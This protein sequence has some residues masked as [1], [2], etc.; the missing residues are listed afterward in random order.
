M[1]ESG[2]SRVPG[3]AIQIVPLRIG[4]SDYR[5]RALSDRQQFADP[6][7]SAER[8]GISSASWPLFGQIWPAGVVLAEAA[9]ALPIAGR[10]ILE[11]G[12]GLALASLVLQRRG[13][14]ITASDH[15]PLV[16]DFLLQ[17]AALNGLP[18]VPYRD[19]PWAVDDASLGRYDVLLG[20]DVLYERDHVALLTGFLERHAEQVA[21]ILITDPGRGHAN[22]LSRALALQGYAMAEERS[23]FGAVDAP[24]YRGRLLR[25]RRGMG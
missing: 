9:S 18:Q 25:Y 10:R 11:F 16:E 24:P 21:E 12:C 5:I 4:G 14:D 6:D 19:A 2:E 23:S 7:G 13:A 17:N 20:A 3:Y 22:T 15:H 8:A 1:A